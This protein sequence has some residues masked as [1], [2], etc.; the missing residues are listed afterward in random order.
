MAA[1]VPQKG[2]EI[3]MRQGQTAGA[4]G[5]DPAVTP[6]GEAGAAPRDLKP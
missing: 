5:N 6:R 2:T 3:F 4:Y 1:T